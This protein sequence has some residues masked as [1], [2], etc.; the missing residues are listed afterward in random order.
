M[1]NYE[2][3]LKSYLEELLFLVFSPLASPQQYELHLLSQF[4]QFVFLHFLF[5]NYYQS[6]CLFFRHLY[7]K[8]DYHLIL[9]DKDVVVLPPTTFT[10]QPT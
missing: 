10:V 1:F 9:A 7:P 2:E 3:T 5:S 4:S 8:T 6:S